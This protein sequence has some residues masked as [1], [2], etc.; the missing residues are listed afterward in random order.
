[1]KQKKVFL[2]VFIAAAFAL[3]WGCPKKAEVTASPEKQQEISG[4]EAAAPST[5]PQPG[6]TMSKIQEEGVNERT[7]SSP[8]GLKPI[9]FDFNKSLIRSDAQQVIRDNAAWLK[10]HPAAKIRIEGNSDERGTKEYN[11]ALGQRKSF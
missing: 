3:L 2:Y 6:E 7:T 11:Q 10:S 4:K 8:M 9:F 5:A 1:M